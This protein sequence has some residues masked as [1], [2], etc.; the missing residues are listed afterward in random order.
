MGGAKTD[1]RA[2]KRRPWRRR[3][4]LS[5]HDIDLIFAIVNAM[6]TRTARSASL[7]PP[8]LA[9]LLGVGRPQHAEFV[10]AEGGLAELLP[11][12]GFLLARG[13][14][15]VLL[16]GIAH[17]IGG[18]GPGRSAMGVAV[19]PRIAAAPGGDLGFRAGGRSQQD[20]RGNHQKLFHV[21]SPSRRLY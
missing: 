4:R 1:T 8:E 7:A 13:S 16:L 2:L 6:L 21:R 17:G 20:Q 11:L 15:P 18:L 9:A 14:I 19:E 12:V 5:E 3:A 10:V